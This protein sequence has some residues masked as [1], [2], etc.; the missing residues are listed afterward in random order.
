MKQKTGLEFMGGK[1][2]RHFYHLI[3][4]QY[5]NIPPE[6]E[7]MAFIIRKEKIAMIARTIET[8]I[9]KKIRINSAGLYIAEVK[10]DQLR[11][12]IEGAQLVGPHATKNVCEFSR[13]QVREW[14]QGK[15]IAVDEVFSEFVIVKYGNDYLGSGKYKEGLILNFV[16]KARRLIDVH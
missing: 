10:E 12:S 13:E 3:E 11:L 7:G 4:Q 2:V 16:P 8:V 9:D 1:E 6:F 15:D 14:L 5:G